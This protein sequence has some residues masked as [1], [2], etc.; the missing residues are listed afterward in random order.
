VRPRRLDRVGQAFEAVAAHQQHVLHAAVADLGEDRQP[1]LGALAAVAQPHAQHVLAALDVDA[2]AQVGGPIDHRAAGADLHD[3][4]VDVED[5]VHRVERP[6]LPL[7][8]LLDDAVGD[9]GDQRW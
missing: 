7:V 9:L 5:R 2:D 4:G 8:E 3:Q 6:R 1:E